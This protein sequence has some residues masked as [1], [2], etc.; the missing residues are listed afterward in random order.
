MT[1]FQSM[2]LD[3][4]SWQIFSSDLQLQNSNSSDISLF[5]SSFHKN[6]SRVGIIIYDLIK[7][8][9]Q[10]YRFMFMQ[11]F[12]REFWQNR[13]RVCVFVF[14]RHECKITKKINWFYELLV[15]KHDQGLTVQMRKKLFHTY[16]LGGILL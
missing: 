14:C 12:C 8:S 7:G 16:R 13:A 2:A 15:I 6:I 3:W 5:W 9:L 4:E 11:T 10:T 1:I